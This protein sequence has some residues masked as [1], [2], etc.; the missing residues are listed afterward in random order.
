RRRHTRSKR[1][2]SSDVCSSDLL[3][4]LKILSLLHTA[5]WHA[6]YLQSDYLPELAQYLYKEL[7][8]LPPSIVVLFHRHYRLHKTR[9]NLLRPRYSSLPYRL[10]KY[11]HLPV[12]LFWGTRDIFHHLSMH[13]WHM[14]NLGNLFVLVLLHASS[15]T[16][17]QNHLFLE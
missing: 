11:H 9:Q 15:K 16:F 13:K 6:R 17:L 8:W 5:E 10:L 3:A 7:S 12:L 2:W 4:Q 1:D 14:D